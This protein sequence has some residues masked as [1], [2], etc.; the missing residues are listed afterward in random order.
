VKQFCSTVGFVVVN[1]VSRYLFIHRLLSWEGSERG[2]ARLGPGF[3]CSEFVYL[4]FLMSL[5]TVL[6][7]FYCFF[8]S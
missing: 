5:N 7:E 3:W 1:F 6:V 8:S 4:F 2:F